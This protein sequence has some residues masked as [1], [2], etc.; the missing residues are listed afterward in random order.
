[1]TDPNGTS[2]PVDGSGERVAR[3]ATGR[4]SEDGP[5]PLAIVRLLRRC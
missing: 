3:P 1:M 2:Q 5:Q 4:G